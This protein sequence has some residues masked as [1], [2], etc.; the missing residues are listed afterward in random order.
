MKQN[1]APAGINI[2]FG[3]RV[4]VLAVCTWFI[5]KMSTSVIG[6]IGVYILLRSVLKII[7]LSVSIFFS[8]LSVIVLMIIIS[9]I[10]VLIF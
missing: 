2:R 7:R 1:D 3:L 8:I 10:V 9:L 4:A 5:C 6:V